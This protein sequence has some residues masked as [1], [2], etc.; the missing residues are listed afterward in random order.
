M[1]DG[2]SDQVSVVIPCFGQARFVGDAVASLRSQSHLFWNCA[3]VYMEEESGNEVREA[4]AGDPRFQLVPSSHLSTLAA[5]NLG[6]SKLKGPY[7]V[8]LDADDILGSSFLERGL[9][10]LAGCPDIKVVYGRAQLFG[11]RSGEFDTPNYCRQTLK[12]RNMIY[13]AAMFRRAAAFPAKALPK[14]PR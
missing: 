9:H 2:V 4:I 14:P 13:S 3:I 5:R 12:S 11:D 6:L 8:M 1:V 10:V 7:A